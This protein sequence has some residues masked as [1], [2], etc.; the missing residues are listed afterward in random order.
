MADTLEKDINQT[1]LLS[2]LGVNQVQ[3]KV[4][5]SQ[6]AVESSNSSSLWTAELATTL[7]FSV[8]GFGL[9]VLFVLAYLL[10]KGHDS[11]SLLR[12]CAL[13]LIIVSAVFLV[14]VGYS[15]EQITPVIGLLGTIAGYLLGSTEKKKNDKDQ[16]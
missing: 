11:S 6:T 14:V 1:E 10:N 7:G 4:T 9:L 2:G 8:L 16:S 12:L 15:Q 13:P 5:Q 3:A